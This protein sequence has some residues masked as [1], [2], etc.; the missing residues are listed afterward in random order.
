VATKY[1]SAMARRGS[2]LAAVVAVAL[3]AACSGSDDAAPATTLEAPTTVAP[4]VPDPTTTVAP[5]TE[6]PTTTVDP[7][8]ALAAEVEADFRETIRLTNE[9]FQDPMNDEKVTAALD[10]Y[11]GANRDFIQARFDEFR[12][13]G[14]VATPNPAIEPALIIELP[15]RLIP[16]SEDVVEMQVCEIDPWIV[17][18]PGAGPD[19]TEA[20]VDSELYTYRSVFFLRDVEGRWR[21]EGGNETGSWTGLLTCPDD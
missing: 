21:I 19:G 6:A 2:A 3:I 12:S 7:A 20:I 9:A 1:D 17:V 4:T 8:Q 18:E 16:P 13:N 14:W 10:G 11:L 5:T 15:A